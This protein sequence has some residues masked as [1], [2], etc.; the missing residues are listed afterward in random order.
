MGTDGCCAQEFV[1]FMRCFSS[2]LPVHLL[3]MVAFRSEVRGLQGCI[4]SFQ[5]TAAMEL[6]VEDTELK[7]MSY[8]I[9]RDGSWEGCG[10]K[11]NV[12]IMRT[13]RL[14]TCWQ[15]R[16]KTSKLVNFENELFAEHR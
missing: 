1:L 14:C 16:L 9:D 5:V 4:M 6:S 8:L 3:I 2:A 12:L 11:H 13:T 10:M 15:L 7:I